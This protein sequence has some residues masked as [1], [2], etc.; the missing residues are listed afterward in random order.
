[1]AKKPQS[2][3]PERGRVNVSISRSTY[4]ALQKLAAAQPYPTP[5]S[6]IADHAISEHVKKEM[7]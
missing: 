1:M 3:P 6:K 2:P 5:L 7:K 4:T